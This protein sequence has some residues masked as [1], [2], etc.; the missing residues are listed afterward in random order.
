ML[1]LHNGK[2]SLIPA[3][4]YS[5]FFNDHFQKCFL[6]ETSLIGIVCA[7]KAGKAWWDL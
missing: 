4:I 2:D 5:K 7:G 1:Q 6:K 3:A